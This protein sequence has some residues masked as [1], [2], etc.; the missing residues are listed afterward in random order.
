MF[1]W[2]VMLPF[3]CFIFYYI[4]TYCV[5]CLWTH[6]FV[7]QTHAV[8]FAFSFVSTSDPKHH[9]VSSFVRPTWFKNLIIKILS[10]SFFLNCLYGHIDM[11]AR[12]WGKRPQRCH[13]SAHLVETTHASLRRLWSACCIFNAFLLCQ[14]CMMNVWFAPPMALGEYDQAPSSP[15]VS[16]HATKE[17][18][19]VP[20]SL[21]KVAQWSTRPNH[22]NGAR[23]G[24]GV[25]V[26]ECVCVCACV[27]WCI[28]LYLHPEPS[29]S[30]VQPLFSQQS[31]AVPEVCLLSQR[32]RP[33]ST[34]L[35]FNLY[36]VGWK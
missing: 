22:V 28:L 12:A 34:I 14:P 31:A 20:D 18:S 16:P 19:N 35:L 25:C 23:R 30:N 24:E 3:I 32:A 33:A 27:S 36:V 21:I 7:F 10:F 29:L 17:W 13:P 4:F 1:S 9:R 2:Q 8:H 15:P 26:I 5:C 6:P 11:N